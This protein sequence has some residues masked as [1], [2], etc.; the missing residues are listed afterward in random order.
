VNDLKTLGIL[1]LACA[2]LALTAST[3]RSQQGYE[4]PSLGT[5]ARRLREERAKEKQK[6]VP[7]FTNDDLRARTT[8]QEGSRE[9]TVPS[10][11][12]ELSR[13]PSVPSPSSSEEHGEEY[14]QSKAAAIRSRLEL[15][16][17]QLAVLEQQWG[18]SST[19]Y[20][21]NPQKTL[22][23]ESTPAFHADLKKL[24]TKIEET[25]RQIADDQKA[26]GDLQVELRRKGGNPGWIR[27]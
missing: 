21:P 15:H 8:P 19:E 7:V 25:K 9:A 2:T 11:T 13:P 16:Q 5:L 4:T 14:F 1:A 10:R 12:E 22:E 20:Y 26:M 3:F 27:Q 23:E 24:R 18:L 17:R 6:P